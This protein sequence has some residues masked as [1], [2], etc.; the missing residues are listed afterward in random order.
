MQT[1]QPVLRYTLDDIATVCARILER[2][3]MDQRATVERRI[4]QRRRLP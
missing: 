3:A 2:R 1:E 4:A